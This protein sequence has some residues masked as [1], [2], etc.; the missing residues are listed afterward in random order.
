MV[1]SRSFSI[2]DI[3]QK[4]IKLLWIQLYSS[5]FTNLHSNS[6]FGLSIERRN[7]SIA[8]SKGKN[9]TSTLGRIHCTALHCLLTMST[10]NIHVS[11]YVHHKQK[12]NQ[13]STWK[14][15]LIFFSEDIRC[16]QWNNLQYSI[17][18]TIFF[19]LILFR[20]SY[21]FMIIYMWY[22]FLYLWEA[23]TYEK[24]VKWKD[25]WTL[26]GEGKGRGERGE[27]SGEMRGERWEN[28]SQEKRRGKKIRRGGEEEN[29]QQGHHKIEDEEEIDWRK[30]GKRGWV[31]EVSH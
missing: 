29:G 11:T 9:K 3:N 10:I 24:M 18:N 7:Q 1:R 19:T 6:L 8:T 12:N 20:V 22:V 5:K 17:I 2:L 23:A 13:P 30:R 4:V 21:L 27:G 14:S 15:L 16:Y 26:A 25:C 31:W 28:K